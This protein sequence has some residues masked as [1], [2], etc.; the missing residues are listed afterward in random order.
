[1]EHKRGLSL[2]IVLLAV[3]SCFFCFFSPSSSIEENPFHSPDMVWSSSGGF[4][5][6]HAQRAT[7]FSVL[8]HFSNIV[9]I[10][11]SVIFLW[12]RPF[13]FLPDFSIEKRIPIQC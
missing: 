11:V 2:V 7:S 3:L 1:M 13:F 12:I 5:N 10:V 9:V 8:L 4:V 6:I